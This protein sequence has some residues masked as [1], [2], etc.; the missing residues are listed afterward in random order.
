MTIPQGRHPSLLSSPAQD[1]LHLVRKPLEIATDPNVR[2]QSERHG[3]FGIFYLLLVWEIFSQ[4]NPA[5]VATC[6]PIIN[7]AY[8]S[9]LL[10]RAWENG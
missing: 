7:T 9:A 5:A 10:A 6:A 1:L 4:K 2:P 3:A 8:T